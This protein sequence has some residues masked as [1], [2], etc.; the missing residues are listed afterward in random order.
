MLE[1]G[2]KEM[3]SMEI[4]GK[5]HGDDSFAA[6]HLEDQDFEWVSQMTPAEYILLDRLSRGVTIVA[7]ATQ[8]FLS[9]RTANRRLAALRKRA[10]VDST[11]ELVKSYHSFRTA[12]D[13]S[14]VD[15]AEHVLEPLAVAA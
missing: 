1:Q 2:S 7:A 4:D 11:R 14:A 5:R 13:M 8:G 10:G 9:L 6:T 15:A 3:T 12:C